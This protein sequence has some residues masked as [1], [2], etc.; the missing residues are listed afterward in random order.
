[1]SPLLILAA[2]FLGRK[3][4][5]TP[6]WPGPSHPPP[7]GGKHQVAPML[8]TK[9]GAVSLA[10]PSTDASQH[11]DVPPPSAPPN[12]EHVAALTLLDYLHG[13]NPNWG[14]PG[15]PSSAVMT[16]QAGMGGGLKPDG[17]YGAQTQARCHELTGQPCPAR[18][19][20]QALA[21]QAAASKAKSLV[22]RSIPRIPGF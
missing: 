18:P 19:S 20:A 9:H 5:T 1:M 2:F 6:G 3:T 15:K 22:S 8:I 4:A 16:A 11:M 21:K 12:P 13:P 17:V 10:P 7:A 14:F